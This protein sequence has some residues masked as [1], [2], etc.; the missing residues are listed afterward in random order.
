MRCSYFFVSTNGSALQELSEGSVLAK[1]TGA[2]SWL[3]F[4]IFNIIIGLYNIEARNHCDY[5]LRYY[6]R[7]GFRT[8]PG[9]IDETQR[10]GYEPP[11][12]RM[13]RS[14]S[15]FVS[16]GELSVGIPAQPI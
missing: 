5:V 13:L 8:P 7:V 16:E 9:I 1:R 12:L 10:R 6:F 3:Q 4:I 11:P 14:P 2:I 15:E